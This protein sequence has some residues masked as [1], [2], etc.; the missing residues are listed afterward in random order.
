MNFNNE[1]LYK[2]LVKNI[3]I[4]CIDI[5]NIYK[6][7]NLLVKRKENPLIGLWWVPGGRVMIGESI[8]DATFRKLK[9][10][11][12][13]VNYNELIRYGLYQDFFD[14][15]SIGDHQ[16]HTFSIVYKVTINDLSSIK[17]DNTSMHWVLKDKL[18]DRLLDKMEVTNG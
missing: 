16:Y 11:L 14:S 2:E 17:I 5:I 6:K 15:S 13:I 12:S 8:D 7:K 1:T 3:P 9:Q 10:E 4:L 18:P